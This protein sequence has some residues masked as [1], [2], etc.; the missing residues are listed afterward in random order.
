MTTAE[1]AT[2]SASV[3]VTAAHVVKEDNADNQV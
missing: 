2:T 1:Q 3:Q